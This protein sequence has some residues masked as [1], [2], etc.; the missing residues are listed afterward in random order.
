MSICTPNDED[1]ISQEMGYLVLGEKRLEQRALKIIS[2]LSQ[3]PTGSIPEF[4]G[5]W[6]ATKATY[7]FFKN[8]V[9][10][11]ERLLAA[12]GQATLQRMKEHPLILILQDTTSFDY[13]AHPMTERLGP[14]DNEK[15]Q[16]FFAHSSLAVTAEGLPL[17]VLA[18]QTWM[19]DPNELGQRH[20]RHQRTIED[21][22]SYKWLQGL[23]ESTREHPA[24]VQAIVVSDRESDIFEYFVH[25]RPANVDLLVRARHDR[26]L[27]DET[28][29]LW[30]ALSSSP[31]RGKIQVEVG[32]RQNQPPRVAE[33]Q[34]YFK[35]VKSRP[36]KK[37]GAHSPQLEPVVLWAVLVREIHP[38]EDIEPLEWLLLTTLE[39]T[40][41]DQACQF[42]EYYTRRWLIERFHFVLKSGCA[43]EQRQLGHADRLICFLAIANVVAWRLLWQ[44]Y[45]GR[46]DSDLPCTVVLAEY[47]WKALYSFIHKTAVAPPEIP[48]L[49]QVTHWI[50][51]LGGFLGRKSDGQPGVKVLW[52]GWR[53]LFDISQT[54]LIFNTS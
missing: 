46:L 23:N 36:P 45:L 7:E 18:Q 20:Q 53:R 39:I 2:D 42:I 43:L 17:G 29:K 49:G 6:A 22:E 31:I 41:F 34:V 1:W 8:S 15:C 40:T 24:Q 26:K 10:A 51:Q 35:R 12:Q 38:P 47:E 50:A 19:R 21:K 13:S 14:L 16:G 4:C 3:N 28:Y 5:D 33:C 9:S 25:P 11:P 48:T 30:L 37:R 44:T 32:R 54:W 52:R 27:M